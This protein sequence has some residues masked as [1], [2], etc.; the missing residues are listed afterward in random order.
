MG[1]GFFS[2]ACQVAEYN[3]IKMDDLQFFYEKKYH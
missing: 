3:L 2:F 1:L